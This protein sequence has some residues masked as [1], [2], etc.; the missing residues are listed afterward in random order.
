M[1][2]TNWNLSSQGSKKKRRMKNTVE[3][4]RKIEDTTNQIYGSSGSR[5]RER[6]G[7]N[8]TQWNNG[9]KL[10]KQGKE[11]NI[12]IHELQQNLNSI[13]PKNCT[14]RHI[15]KLSEV[16][17]FIGV[18]LRQLFNNDNTTGMCERNWWMLFGRMGMKDSRSGLYTK[19]SVFQFTLIFWI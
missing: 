15:I 17:K 11:M 3:S 2:T 16:K 8:L 6:K 10:L 9:W 4:L 1:K 7:R 18:F 5:E 13:H 14:S 12:Q 19:K